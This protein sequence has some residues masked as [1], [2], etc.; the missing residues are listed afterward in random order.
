MGVLP[1][2]SCATYF[3][4]KLPLT[5]PQHSGS[6]SPVVSLQKVAE[7]RKHLTTLQKKYDLLL[8][9]NDI[10][11]YFNLKLKRD[12]QKRFIQV[13]VCVNSFLFHV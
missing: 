8:F 10:K 2:H 6:N 7:Y 3:T 12:A 9:K 13:I 1:S 4:R 5:V 11:L